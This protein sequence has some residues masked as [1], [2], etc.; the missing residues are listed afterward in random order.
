MWIVAFLSH[1]KVLST[2][3]GPPFDSDVRLQNEFWNTFFLGEAFWTLESAF[4]AWLLHSTYTL[5]WPASHLYRILIKWLMLPMGLKW[6]RALVGHLGVPKTSYPHHYKNHCGRLDL[7]FI[8]T[9]PLLGL[10]LKGFE[11]CPTVD[12]GTLKSW[13]FESGNDVIFC[14]H[15][16]HAWVFLLGESH[17]SIAQEITCIYMYL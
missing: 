7:T 6:V 5:G 1:S 11:H 10:A 2:C 15:L 14:L 4:E 9:Y 13:P 16:I 17:R 12:L 8:Q 3:R